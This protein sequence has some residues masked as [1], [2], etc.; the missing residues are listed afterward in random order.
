[1]EKILGT[2]DQ[3]RLMEYMKKSVI[4]ASH[5]DN[6]GG[7]YRK[8]SES[9]KEIDNLI[10]TYVAN[11]NAKLK[12]VVLGEV[13]AGKSSLVN[14]LLKSKVAF[15]NVVEAT[16]LVSEISYGDDNSA[17]LVYKDG[18]TSA[19]KTFSELNS[20]MQKSMDQLSTLKDVSK[21]VVTRNTERL[22]N[23][24]LVDTPGLNTITKEN[25]IRTT[26]YIAEA[27]LIMWVLNANHLGQSDI[28]ESIEKISDDYGKKSICVINRI[29][30]LTNSSTE[31]LISYVDDEIGYL[32][33]RIFAVSAQQYSMSGTQ[34]ENVGNIDS[35]YDYLCSE[36][37]SN[38]DKVHK[39]LNAQSFFNI[40]NRDISVHKK[41]NEDLSKA[42]KEIDTRIKVID[43]ISK[44]A[45]SDIESRLIRWANNEFFSKERI[46]L[47]ECKTAQELKKQAE[48]I[49]DGNNLNSQIKAK[50]TELSRVL[51]D[52]WQDSLTESMN[53][54]ESSLSIR[55]VQNYSTDFIVE[56]AMNRRN[57]TDTV[58]KNAM[59]GAA[60]GAATGIGKL[61][62]TGFKKNSEERHWI[63]SQCNQIEL[64]IQKRLE[65][66]ILPKM[67]DEMRRLND[68][69]YHE[70]SPML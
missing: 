69:Y 4:R 36:I 67:K 68:S 5:L 44:N 15:T 70:L 46:I 6:N 7:F 65:T 49:V 20:Y 56:N 8:Y 61:V 17:K 60:V 12:V 40:I 23:I 3:N 16:T 53:Q 1:M 21:I 63:E 34:N 41:A 29:D 10:D 64:E 9:I 18:K 26:E 48:V 57:S 38:A 28:V 32:C 51:F 42:I 52:F 30:E 13:K 11:K 37:D 54:I 27:D 25:A 33:D 22:K 47:A 50:A 14:A 19:F 35:L 2:A 43:E 59:V 55:S 62:L 58:A 45:K 39:L 66:D 31:R 24:I